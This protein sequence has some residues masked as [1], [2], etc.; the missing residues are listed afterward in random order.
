MNK[1]IKDKQE[2]LKAIELIENLR[3]DLENEIKY[4]SF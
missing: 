1:Q 3:D 2:K 4:T